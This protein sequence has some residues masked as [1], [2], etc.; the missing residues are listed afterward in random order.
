MLENPNF[1]EIKV[2]AMSVTTAIIV[3]VIDVLEDSEIDLRTIGVALL[4]AVLTGLAGY[5]VK[6]TNPSRSAIDTVKS[7]GL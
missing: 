2:L 3:A 4:T 5:Q 7:R 6:E 1:P